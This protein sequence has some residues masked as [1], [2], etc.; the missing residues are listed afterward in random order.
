M[1]SFRSHGYAGYGVRY[2]PFFDSKLAIATAANFGLVGNGRL[3]VLDI[4]ATGQI[5]PQIHFDTQDGVFGLAWSE[6]NENQI[7]AG[8]GDGSLKLFDINAPR[9]PL[10]A[11]NQEHTRDVSSVNWNMVDKNIFASASWDGS[12]KIW[13]P[14]RLESITTFSTPLL[15]EP[16]A[17]PLPNTTTTSNQSSARSPSIYE[18]KFSPHAS[19]LL[20]SA[21][22]DSSVQL[23]DMRAPQTPTLRLDR[24]HSGLEC[25]TLDWNKYR[26]TVLLSAGVDKLV[27]VWDTRNTKMPANEFVGH[28]FAVRNAA[29]SPHAPDIALSTS[30]DMTARVWHDQTTH[31]RGANMNRQINLF[32]KHTEFVVGC[33]WSLWGEPGWVATIGWDETL[34]AWKAT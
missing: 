27:K 8:C 4:T 18:A 1:L 10:R 15:A 31:R 2:S 28:E 26:P 32:D 25:L 16:P 20:A 21:Q 14:E 12:I 19:T 6:L 22:W 30:Y 24:A 17:V 7:L 29:W 3:Y 5:V 9:F 33:D 11:F 13:T 34:Y 23:W